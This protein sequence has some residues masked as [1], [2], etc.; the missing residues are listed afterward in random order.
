MN[1]DK[2]APYVFFSL[3]SMEKYPFNNY[4]SIKNQMK[5]TKSNILIFFVYL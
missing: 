4:Y 2:R 5:A 1:K 3:F